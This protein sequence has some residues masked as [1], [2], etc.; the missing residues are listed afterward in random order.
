M[1]TPSPSPYRIVLQQFNRAADEMDLSPEVRAILAEPM[2]EIIVNFPVTM[3]DGSVQVFRGF[4]IQHNNVL[5]PFKGG[6][7]FHPQVSRDAVKALATWT[8]WKC[9][10]V[11]IPFG[12]AKGG[13]RC[14]P[15]P[16][17]ARELERLTRRFT[18]A[19]QTFIGPE[20]DILGPGLNTDAQIMAWMMDTYIASV[21]PGQRGTYRHVVTGKPMELGGSPGRDRAAGRGLVEVVQADLEAGGLPGWSSPGAGRELGGLDVILQGFGEVGSAAAIT[22]QER[23]ARLLAVNDQ[24]GSLLAR[25]GIDAQALATH[26]SAH[27]GV[28]GYPEAEAISREEFLR[29]PAHLFI[30]AALESQITEE[31]CDWLDVRLIAEGANGPIAPEAES[32]LSERGIR[33]LPDILASAGGVTVSY[34]EWVQ[35]KNSQIW[36][37]AEVH[38]RLVEALRENHHEVLQRARD[39]G[40]D[41]RT[42]AYILALERLT[43]TYR[44]RG[45]FP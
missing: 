11:N 25:T 42:A 13:I 36:T 35:N 27:G 8:T 34:F 12:G 17:S 10:V 6:I 14:D 18:Y 4:R 30:P 9:A 24:T 16:L 2:N 26:V 1:A 28:V 3:D 33:I 40:L 41:L 5:G 15:A 19:I 44:L 38:R 31:N 37:L 7:R 39:R 32:R 29:T 45:I 23:G 22:L 43:A 20:R 21:A